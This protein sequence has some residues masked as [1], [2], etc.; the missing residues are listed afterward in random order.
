MIIGQHR[1]R[2][3]KVVA[4]T[5][6]VARNALR[7]SGCGSLRVTWSIPAK[8]IATGDVYR[9]TFAVVDA[10]GRRSKTIS[11]QSRW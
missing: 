8:L 4:R 10:A 11:G 1:L 9:V 5:T 7:V 3:G 6:T 2:N